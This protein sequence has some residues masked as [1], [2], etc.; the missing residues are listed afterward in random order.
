MINKVIKPLETTV[1]ITY[2]IIVEIPGNKSS[3]FGLGTIYF[4]LHVAAAMT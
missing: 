2:F 1:F 4:K 3:I